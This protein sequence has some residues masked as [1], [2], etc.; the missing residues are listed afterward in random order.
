[1]KMLS[2][3]FIAL[4][5]CLIQLYQ[6]FISPLLGPSK[7]R[8]IPTCSEYAKE[9]LQKYGLMKG[10][11]LSVKRIARCAPWGSDGYDPVP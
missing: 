2:R 6:W 7:C 10:F 3:F 4:L 9:A 8:Y 1:M 5:Q 11:Y